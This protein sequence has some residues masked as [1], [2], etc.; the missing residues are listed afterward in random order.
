ME[1]PWVKPEQVKD[2]TSSSKVL[3]RSDTQLAFDIARAEKYVIYYTHN[4]FK[5]PEYSNRLPP[6]VT[7]AVI[8]L[9]EAYAKQGKRQII[10]VY[11]R[12]AAYDIVQLEHLDN[13]I[14]AKVPSYL[15]FLFLLRL[16]YRTLAH[17]QLLPGS[18]LIMQLDH[19]PLAF[20]RFGLFFGVS[21]DALALETAV[22][23]M[24]DAAAVSSLHMSCRL[25]T[26][27]PYQP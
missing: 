8:L 14:V 3:Q 26:R 1:R 18:M 21:L 13:Q 15:R 4:Q 7:R 20:P 5:A 10:G 19:C 6:D 23:T 17:K 24:T 25:L 11:K 12:S 9:A 16:R 22:H 27:A 2:Y